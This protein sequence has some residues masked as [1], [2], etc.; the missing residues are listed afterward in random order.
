MSGL[1]KVTVYFSKITNKTQMNN[2]N[3]KIPAGKM[4]KLYIK[5][6]FFLIIFSNLSQ[7]PGKS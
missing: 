7:N 1:V 2:N 5:K 6:N 4:Y 3:N